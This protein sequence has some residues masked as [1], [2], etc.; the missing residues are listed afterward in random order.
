MIWY[1]FGREES[2]EGAGD[3][4]DDDNNAFYQFSSVA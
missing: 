1:H 2:S 4:G 3:C